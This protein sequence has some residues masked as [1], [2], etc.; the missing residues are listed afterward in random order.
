MSGEVEDGRFFVES[1]LSAV[2]MVDVEIN[3]KHP[4][5]PFFLQSEA[6]GHRHV[7]EEAEAHASCRQGMVTWRPHQGESI[8]HLPLQ[9]CPH[10]VY[11]PP[12]GHQ[13]CLVGPWPH[14]G[15]EV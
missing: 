15:V 2:A 10:C 9:H 1:V 13:R 4:F 8:V 12:G 7:V 11:Q 14:V 5:Q 3:D 6:G